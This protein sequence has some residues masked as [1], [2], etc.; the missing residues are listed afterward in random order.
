MKRLVELTLRLPAELLVA[1]VRFYQRA[2][3]PLL[4]QHCRF[5]PTCSEYFIGAVRKYGA[6]R[7]SL[8]GVWRVLRCNPLSRGGYDPP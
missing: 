1:A 8:K 3:S 2:I 7:G 6:L 4:G 5:V